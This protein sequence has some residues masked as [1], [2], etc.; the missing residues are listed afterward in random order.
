MY[1]YLLYFLVFSFL[2]WCTELVFYF[3]KTERFVNRGLAKGPICPI[4]GVGL[5]LSYFLL[6]TVENFIALA[7]LSMAITTLVEFTVGW[8]IESTL[9]VRLWDYS[10]EWGNI[11][12]YVCPRFSAVWG[13]VSALV[14]SFIPLLRPLIDAVRNPAGYILASVLFAISALD[15]IT[16][17]IKRK[18]EK[19]A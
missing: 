7:F 9:G 17:I 6:G 8:I 13:V 2:G 11:R 1:D 4:Y 16:Q 14:V 19:H 18:D 12:G 10:G 3:F 5:C 15:I